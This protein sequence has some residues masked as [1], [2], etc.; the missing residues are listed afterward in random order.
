MLSGLQFGKL[1]G[2]GGGG[3]SKSPDASDS[4]VLSSNPDWEKS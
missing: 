4:N 2:G 3:G 1:F